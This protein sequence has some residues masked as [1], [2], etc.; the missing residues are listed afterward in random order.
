MP[1]RERMGAFDEYVERTE[2]C[3]LWTAGRTGS[4]YG[5]F[6]PEAGT[7]MLAHRFAWVRANGPIPAGLQVCHRCDTPACV[8]LEHLFLGTAAD[9]AR[10]RDGKR[11]H[12]HGVRVHTSK[13][14]AET[15]R[16]IRAEYAAGTTL[17]AL[18]AQHQVTRQAV[19]RIVRRL[20]WKHV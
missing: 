3:W 17:T 12:V 13:L 1:K 19:F 7:Q 9:N 20:C 15:V 16:Q 6:Y 4:G 18:A 10:D 11:R 14:T 8:R 5:A 2:S